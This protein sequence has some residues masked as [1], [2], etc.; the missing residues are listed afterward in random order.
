MDIYQ[1]SIVNNSFD[2]SLLFRLGSN[3]GFFSEYN[4]MLLTMLYCLKHRIKFLLSSKYSN[5]AVELGWNDYFEPFV[6]EYNCPIVAANQFN[7]RYDYPLIRKKDLLYSNIYKLWSL[8]RGIDYKTQDLIWK[9][10]RQSVEETFSFPQ[11]NESGN[12]EDLCRALNKMIWRYNEITEKEITKHFEKICLP[13]HYVSLHIRRGDKIV[14]ARFEEYDKYLK[15]IE[16]KTNI[17]ECFVFTDDYQ[18]IVDL[19]HNYPMWNFYTLTDKNE[20]G[21]YH[22][23]FSKISKEE[24]RKLT[25]KMFASVEIISRSEY[26]VGTL[27]SNPGMY[28]YLRMPKGRCMGVDFDEWII[29]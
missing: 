14:E 16:K 21:Y 23:K 20:S 10:H 18:V 15:K 13:K 5:M 17:R 24:K 2:K 9:A 25:V 29:W 19:K 3:A 22:E 7:S 11:L 12:T 4:N 6:R 26:F 28:L 1:Y 27:S 8:Y